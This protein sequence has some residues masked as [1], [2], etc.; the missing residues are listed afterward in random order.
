MVSRRQFLRGRIAQAKPAL[1]P[2]GALR[3][4]DFL[5]TC[6]RCDDCIPVCPNHI[7]FSDAEGYPALS[8]AHA[9]CTFCGA[10]QRACIPKA[11]RG[12]PSGA[13]LNAVAIIGPDCV[14]LDGVVCRVCGDACEA[15]AIRFPPRAGGTPLPVVMAERCTGC[16][17]CV[18]ACPSK[19][20]G[21]SPL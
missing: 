19:A 6:T 21:V 10:C 3:E 15:E 12:D 5:A 18:G 9:A 4:A 11:L 2:P 1:R 17:A 13:K 20:I 7:V 8:F 16:G 14:A